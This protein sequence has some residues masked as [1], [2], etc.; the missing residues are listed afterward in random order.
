ML[1]NITVHDQ[2]AQAF[3]LCSK[4]RWQSPENNVYLCLQPNSI[5]D[6]WCSHPVKNL[7]TCVK[8]FNVCC[9]VTKTI[10]NTTGCHGNIVAIQSRLG[11]DVHYGF[12]TV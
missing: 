4:R 11:H 5:S 10:L 12:V 3:H 8:Q 6:A 2:I 9:L 7:Y 1:P